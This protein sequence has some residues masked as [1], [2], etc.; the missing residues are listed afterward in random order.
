MHKAQCISCM[1]IY[2]VVTYT[3]SW[4]EQ[5]LRTYEWEIYRGR[6]ISSLL[7]YKK[8]LLHVELSFK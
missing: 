8:V 3:G 7:D 1:Y 5:G 6:R 4:G 2:S